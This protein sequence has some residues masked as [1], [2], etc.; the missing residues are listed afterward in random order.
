MTK[1]ILRKKCV[2]CKKTYKPNSNSQKYCRKCRIFVTK[3]LK[4]KRKKITIYEEIKCETCNKIILKKC[5]NKT[6]CKKCRILRDKK[7]SQEYLKSEKGKAYKRKY[8]KLP[9]IKK[10][11][12]KYRKNR[13]KNDS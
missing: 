8:E 5:W 6:F 10:R 9:N 7:K 3:K 4:E 2:I 12:N 13:R 11:K 1:L